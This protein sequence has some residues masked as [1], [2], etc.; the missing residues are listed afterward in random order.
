M[1]ELFESL[2]KIE[3]EKG[4][5]TQ[6]APLPFAS[7]P[8]QKKATI[9]KG[10][11]IALIVVTL[12]L[13]GGWGLLRYSN[14]L[15]KTR[16]A[17]NHPYNPKT[18]VRSQRVSAIPQEVKATSTI[19]EVEK[20]AAKAETAPTEKPPQPPHTQTKGAASTTQS[21]KAYGL[22]NPT[23][24]VNTPQQHPAEA[25]LAPPK[26]SETEEAKGTQ[27]SPSSPETSQS[28]RYTYLLM[29]ANE[30]LGKGD[31][32]KALRLYQDYVVKNP[33]NNKVWNNIGVI[34]LRMGEPKKALTVLRKAHSLNPQDPDIAVNRAI[35]LWEKGEKDVAQ[36]EADILSLRDDLPPLAVYNLA[37][38]LIRMNKTKE[39][40]TLV[41]GAEGRLGHTSL[42]VSL[43]P[44][45][46]GLGQEEGQKTNTS[47]KDR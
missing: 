20:K 19:A 25:T 39:A 13:I 17:I 23:G 42:L 18:P 35:A 44:Y 46:R 41:Q 33:K 5:T 15:K 10:L 14:T 9:G 32:Q 3:R 43:H 4:E 40:Y 31:M 12:A 6:G 8:L 22:G 29:C 27:P 1:S 45:F 7:P 11:A 38:L 21:A 16:L 36:R 30:A 2:K 28:Y 37:V 26:P 47:A 24:K 34:Y